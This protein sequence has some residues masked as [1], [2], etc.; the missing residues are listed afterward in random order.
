VPIRASS[1]AIFFASFASNKSAKIRAIIPVLWYTDP[2][3]KVAGFRRSELSQ[4][5]RLSIK[6]RVL[7]L[8]D[9]KIIRKNERPSTFRSR[10]VSGPRAGYVK[11]L[12][13]PVNP[14]KK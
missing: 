5:A 14:V 10:G 9:K 6:V 8:S 13:N 12:V 3:W 7:V 2:G 1:G 11:N 4:R